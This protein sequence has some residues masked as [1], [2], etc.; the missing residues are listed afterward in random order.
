[1]VLCALSWSLK[2]LKIMFSLI[3]IGLPT[4]A[5]SFSVTFGLMSCSYSLSSFLLL[6]TFLVFSIPSCPSC[7]HFFILPQHTPQP[8]VF[9]SLKTNALSTKVFQTIVLWPSLARNLRKNNK[10]LKSK[11]KVGERG[12]E[13]SCLIEN[14]WNSFTGTFITL[15][16][17]NWLYLKGQRRKCFKVMSSSHLEK[18][19]HSIWVWKTMCLVRFQGYCL[20][21]QYLAF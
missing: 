6:F 2:T 16:N 9:L 5:V 11:K 3:S 15:Q 21:N 4:L 8:I 13:S 12:V 10:L 14:F 19:V 17:G 1:M 7:H 20:A 18:N